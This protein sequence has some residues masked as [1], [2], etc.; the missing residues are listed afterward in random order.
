MVLTGVASRVGITVLENLPHGV[1]S[2]V[3]HRLVA[4]IETTDSNEHHVLV[5]GLDGTVRA[6]VYVLTTKASHP[7]FGE[8]MEVAIVLISVLRLGIVMNL[9]ETTSSKVY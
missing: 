1:C 2:A 3:E 5:R 6:E 7:L 4:I 9:P 8:E